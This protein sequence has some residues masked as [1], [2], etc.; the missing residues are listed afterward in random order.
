MELTP[1]EINF[2]GADK[3]VL[4]TK[5]SLK[6]L[7][8]QDLPSGYTFTVPRGYKRYISIYG[9]LITG[10]IE[11][12]T[13]KTNSGFLPSYASS[14][15]IFSYDYSNIVAEELLNPQNKLASYVSVQAIPN[16]GYLVSSL[17]PFRYLLE[18]D[19]L[20]HGNGMTMSIL[21]RE[22]QLSNGSHMLSSPLKL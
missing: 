8:S 21:I 14:Q 9:Q 1:T 19:F 12:E 6:R 10:Y 13:I 4:E 3:N 11:N 22:N 7:I 18:F 2:L 20:P 16:T 15:A 5:T 17:D